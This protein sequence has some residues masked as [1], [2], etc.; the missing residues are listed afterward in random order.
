MHRP[1]QTPDRAGLP[2]PGP[3]AIARAAAPAGA[4][5]RP[6]HAR[7]AAQLV[8]AGPGLQRGAARA[9][10]LEVLQLAAAEAPRRRA[11]RAR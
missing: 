2:E 7:G 4:L 1:A 11:P 6:A 10:A 8:A 3:E 5:A 9:V